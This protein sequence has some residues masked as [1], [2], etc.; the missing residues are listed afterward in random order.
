MTN[1]IATYEGRKSLEKIAWS[2]V[3]REFERYGYQVAALALERSSA[4]PEVEPMLLR[5]NDPPL[6]L[7]IISMPDG[8]AY[9]PQKDIGYL[10][11]VKAPT[12]GRSTVAIRLRD[13]LALYLWEALI[14]AVAEN[15]IRAALA[16]EMPAPK[17]II[18]PC[19]PRTPWDAG[20]LKWALEQFPDIEPVEGVDV[21][22][23]SKA[24]FGVWE[25]SAFAPIE[26]YL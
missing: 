22:F 6:L 12:Q 9:N 23:G 13:L 16:K 25:L 14:I 18:V 5:A 26:F 3:K 21:T 17:C 7:M 10:F 24:P 20:A 4:F 15:E 1:A 19:E 8:F 2:K 11:E